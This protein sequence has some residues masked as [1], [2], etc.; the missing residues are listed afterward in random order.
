MQ[1]T[2]IIVINEVGL[3]ARPAAEFVRQAAQF[4]SE[5]QIR[6]L[7]RNTDWVDAK[8]ILGVLTLGVECGHEIE[9]R[10]NGQ[11]EENAIHSLQAL[12]ESDFAGRL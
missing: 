2:R 1:S 11:D 7:T 8:S 4:V 9:V 5:I 12:I 3:H 10:A 6:N